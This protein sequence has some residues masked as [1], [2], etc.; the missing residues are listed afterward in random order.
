[1]SSG[2]LVRRGRCEHV[3]RGAGRLESAH[4]IPPMMPVEDRVALDEPQSQVGGA[5]MSIAGIED[6]EELLKRREA[7]RQAKDFAAADR[8]RDEITAA[9]YRIIDTPEGPRL[10]RS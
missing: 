3:L 4:V 8:L 7:A 5:G 10:E 6:P 9:G 2:A 1:M